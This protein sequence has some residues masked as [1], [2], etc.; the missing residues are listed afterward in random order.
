MSER[1]LTDRDRMMARRGDVEGVRSLLQ[2]HPHLI[3]YPT[4]AH[5][6]S[7]LWEA[8]RHGRLDL[9]KV[10]LQLGA[11]VLGPGRNRAE[12]LVLLSPLAIARIYRRSAIEELLIR[13]GAQLSLY[14]HAFFGDR[15]EVETELRRDPGCLNQPHPDDCIWSTTLLHYAV[16]G[17]QVEMAHFLCGEGADVQTHGPLLLECAARKGSRA[18]L[19]CCLAYGARA[20]TLS[21]Y[22]ALVGG[23]DADLLGDLA[24]KGLDVN[25]E[26]FGMPALVYASR[27]DKGEHPDWIRY[28][29]AAGA[30]VHIA[31]RKG[32]TALHTAAA[33]GFCEVATVLLESGAEL[34]ARTLEGHTP[35]QLARKKKRTDMI[36]LLLKA[37]AGE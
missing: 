8:V 15:S 29:L 32:R 5:N 13:H 2:Q 30:D 11:P 20:E 3:G 19:E 4:G 33:A 17:E 35:L 14:D 22:A 31:D 1:V 26:N 16:A 12:H 6:R 18:L 24:E 37:G 21:A 28:L 36:H 27:G 25:A 10:L 7:L 34:E 23:G 9:V